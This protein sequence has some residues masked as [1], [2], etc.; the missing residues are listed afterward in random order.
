MNAHTLLSK[1]TP[2]SDEINK[3][4]S[5]KQQIIFIFD[6]HFFN[7]TA[8]SIHATFHIAITA[9]RYSRV[10][11]ERNYLL[12]SQFWW[13]N[14]IKVKTSFTRPHSNNWINYIIFFESF[15][16]KFK[17]RCNNIQQTMPAILISLH[18]IGSKNQIYHTEYVKVVCKYVHM[19]V[20]TGI[21]A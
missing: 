5:I 3:F 16:E 8:K 12:F 17:V 19:H 4:V 20:S 18:A 2:F 11:E 13:F 7:E 21:H 15:P 14:E 1:T 10:N 9:S 6:S